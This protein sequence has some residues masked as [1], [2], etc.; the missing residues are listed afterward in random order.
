[1]WPVLDFISRHVTKVRNHILTFLL[2]NDR[3]HIWVV[4][5][6]GHVE[7]GLHSHPER[8][9]GQS[10]LGLQVG[11]GTLLEQLTCQV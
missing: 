2:Q 5:S 11:V 1:M 7:G 6:D 3:N 8:V 9:I 4:V 10:F